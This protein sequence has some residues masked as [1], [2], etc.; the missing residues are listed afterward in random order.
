MT[1][2]LV[3]FEDHPKVTT[4]KVIAYGSTKYDQEHATSLPSQALLTRESYQNCA[5][6]ATID[7]TINLSVTGTYSATATNTTGITTT[8]GTSL[9]MSGG[10]SYLGA[11][12]SQTTNF[13]WNQAVSSTSS[14]S[15]TE[16]HASTRSISWTI[17]AP[18]STMGII[19]LLAYQTTVD[20]SYSTTAVV[21][22]LLEPN[23]SGLTSAKDLLSEADRT[24]TISGV[25]RLSEVSNGEYRTAPVPGNP[26]CEEADVG[27]LIIQ[28]SN[29]SI[30][31]G[32]KFDTKRF[33]PARFFVSK[34]SPKSAV[35]PGIGIAEG[36]TI[37]PPDG[38]SYQI[39]YSTDIF[40]PAPQCG[41]NDL[42]VPILG[43]FT[44]EMRHYATYANGILVSQ[45]DEPVDTFKECNS[46]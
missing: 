39:I 33:E 44:R 34:E 24:M 36:P 43:T 41:M 26:K 18:A 32:A 2:V 1:Q 45:W 4:S 16:T 46:P 37:G 17:H 29:I 8:I 25:L 11:S 30:P 28:K 35:F 7:N 27:N 42:G 15:N 3:P 20:V 6:G 19:E 5:P 23:D 13:S 21:D 9:S 10:F 22:G 38:T 12:A 40:Q 14:N 31:P